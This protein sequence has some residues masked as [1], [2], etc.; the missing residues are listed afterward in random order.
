MTNN[1]LIDCVN[2]PW[3]PRGSRPD[4]LFLWVSPD[5]DRRELVAEHTRLCYHE[6]KTDLGLADWLVTK[7]AREAVAERW[8]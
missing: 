5:W 8:H 2:T 3:N 4:H 7:G 6:K 1:K